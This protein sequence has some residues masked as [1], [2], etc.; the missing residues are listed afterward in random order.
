MRVR[1]KKSGK[2]PQAGKESERVVS[3]VCFFRVQLREDGRGWRGG[4]D[5][6][7]AR[8]AEVEMKIYQK[9]SELNSFIAVLTID[10]GIKLPKSTISPVKAG[11]A[12]PE[13]VTISLCPITRSFL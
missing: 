1:L 9:G 3:W 5:T 12:A 6:V 8:I 2:Q 4:V 7:H 10:D 13:L 11:L